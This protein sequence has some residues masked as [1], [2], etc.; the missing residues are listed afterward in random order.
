MIDG[1]VQRVYKN[2]FP[3]TRSFWLWS[4]T[5]FSEQTYVV[6]EDQRYTYKQMLD[7]TLRAAAVFQED[8][9]VQKGM[10]STCPCPITVLVISILYPGD[11]VAICS[12]NYPSYYTAFWASRKPQATERNLLCSFDCFPQIS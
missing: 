7:M 11:R 10:S 5:E 3:S 2:L 4:T 8:Y 1:R 12:R 9:G 6:F